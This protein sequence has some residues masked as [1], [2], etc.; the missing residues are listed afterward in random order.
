MSTNLGGHMNIYGKDLMGRRRQRHRSEFKAAL[1]QQC[2]RP[3][4]SIAVLALAHSL[5]ANMLRKWVIDVPPKPKATP[6]QTQT[7]AM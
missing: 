4:V 6:A 1:I 5:N 7:Q 2:M 3:S